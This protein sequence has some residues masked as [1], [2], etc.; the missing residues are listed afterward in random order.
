MRIDVS[1]WKPGS[2]FAICRRLKA[3]LNYL[4]IEDDGLTRSMLEI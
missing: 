3:S 2:S 1:P 4:S